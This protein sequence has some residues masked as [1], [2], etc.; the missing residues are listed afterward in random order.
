V[1]SVTGVSHI[2]TKN[3]NLRTISYK[4]KIS[5]ISH[6]VTRW[7]LKARARWPNSLATLTVETYRIRSNPFAKMKWNVVRHWRRAVGSDYEIWINLRHVCLRVRIIRFIILPLTDVETTQDDCSTACVCVCVC[8]CVCSCV[9]I[10]QVGRRA[11]WSQQCWWH[12]STVWARYAV[13]SFDSP[14]DLIILADLTHI[15]GSSWVVT[16]DW[17]DI[18]SQSLMAVCC[19]IIIYVSDN[20]WCATYRSLAIFVVEY[21]INWLDTLM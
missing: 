20:T 12:P 5:S 3:C 7:L 6:R 9:Q 15:L 21:L 11:V 19:R 17:H 14:L 18:L 4:F 13:T 8:V 16:P 1:E 2:V 10:S